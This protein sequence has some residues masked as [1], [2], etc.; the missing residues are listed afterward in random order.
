MQNLKMKP[1]AVLTHLENILKRIKD[2]WEH[3]ALIYAINLV[4]KEIKSEQVD[5][6]SI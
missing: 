4:I 3:D 6:G 1:E 5:D 2:T